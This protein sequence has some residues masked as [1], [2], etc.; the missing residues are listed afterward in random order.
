ANLSRMFAEATGSRYRF[1]VMRAAM[2]YGARRHPFSPTWNR[3]VF[4]P[5][6]RAVRVPVFGVGGIRTREEAD[7]ILGAG[8]A[9]MI[10][11]GRPFYAEADLPAHFLAG[12]GAPTACESSNHCVVPQMLGLPGVCYNPKVKKAA[13][14]ARG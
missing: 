14:R 6:K 13:A 4:A 5:V 7:S 9:D 10:G 12:D 8:D 1:H 11:I 2:W 3:G